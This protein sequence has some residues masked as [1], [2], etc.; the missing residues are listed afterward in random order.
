MFRL[1]WIPLLDKV[2]MYLIDPHTGYPYQQSEHAKIINY[3]I[4]KG[5]FQ[6]F[7]FADRRLPPKYF[8][9]EFFWSLRSE[10]R[11]FQP[12]LNQSPK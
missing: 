4:V 3:K 1:K 10:N 5:S 12:C 2:Y 7:Y 9:L 6:Y 11:R 8:A